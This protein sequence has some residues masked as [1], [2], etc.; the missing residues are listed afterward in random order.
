MTLAET[1][2]LFYQVSTEISYTACLNGAES[3][4]LRKRKY[5]IENEEKKVSKNNH[6]AG[7]AQRGAPIFYRAREFH[8][9]TEAGSSY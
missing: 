9:A 2:K 7:T 4:V 1:I 6:R 3:P 8:R 5:C